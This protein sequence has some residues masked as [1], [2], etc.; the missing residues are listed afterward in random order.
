LIVFLLIVEL[1]IGFAN[2]AV[3]ANAARAGAREAIKCDGD[4][5]DI[6]SPCWS[7]AQNAASE[8]AQ[9]IIS[10]KNP[11]AAGSLDIECD[12]MDGSCPD[13]I[14]GGFPIRATYSFQFQFFLLPAVLPG[15]SNFQQTGRVI[16]RK[17]PD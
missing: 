12:T 10:L 1:G 17:L 4:P 5:T 15:V 7:E 16:M 2:Q 11:S 13:P 8:A 9:S 6:T 3:L 14:P